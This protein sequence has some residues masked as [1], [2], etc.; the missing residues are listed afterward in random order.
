MDLRQ[1][2]RQSIVDRVGG[3]VDGQKFLVKIWN[4]NGFEVFA[5]LPDGFGVT[6][7]SEY[8]APFD[9]N[10]LSSGLGKAYAIAGFSQRIGMRMKKFYTN[11]EPSEI[12]I[13]ME[14]TTEENAVRDVIYP[15]YSL[16]QMALGST[17]SL[18]D[19]NKATIEF[20][21]AINNGLKSAADT[22]GVEE[23]I[24]INDTTIATV[25]ISDDNAAGK[26]DGIL[27]S[28]GFIRA[29]KDVNV[30]FG[31]VML[32]ERCYITSVATTFSNV[33]DKSGYPLSATC[34]VTITPEK[35]PIAD[36]MTNVYSSKRWSAR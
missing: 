26:V 25:N 35:Y 12:S 2:S 27:R 34:T 14:F 11:P 8:T 19:F 22:F 10:G 1:F 32:W 15:V 20:F 28:I 30:Q 7:G 3:D 36:D 18:S 33:L 16:T 23:P 13:E 17:L 29:P 21:T 4:A 6:V 5:P 31:N 24:S 9:V